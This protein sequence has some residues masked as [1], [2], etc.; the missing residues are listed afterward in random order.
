MSKKKSN[1]N[2]LQGMQCP[3]CKSLE[4][5]AIEVTITF[6]LFDE[7]TDDQVSGTEWKD[8]AYCE[9]CECVFTGTV[10]DFTIADAKEGDC[11]TS[12]GTRNSTTPTAPSG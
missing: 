7:G 4:P 2:C 6:K 8:D 10:K 3:K 12:A 9:C 11:G 1:S 5:F